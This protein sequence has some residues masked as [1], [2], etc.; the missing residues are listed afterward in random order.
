MLT[1]RMIDWVNIQQRMI[2]GGLSDIP[3]GHF[4]DS[5]R[6]DDYLYF[7]VEFDTPEDELM[8]LMRWA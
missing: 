5:Y 6:K 7:M 8:F 1:Y 3:N 4:H 2:E